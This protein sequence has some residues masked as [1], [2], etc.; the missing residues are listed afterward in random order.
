MYVR[1]AVLR[2]NEYSSSLL[3]VFQA[4]FELRD[5]GELQPHEEEW[6]EQELR[7]LRMHLKSPSC[8]HD[9]GNHRAICWFHPRAKR[10]IAKV[11]SIAALLNE[12]GCHV[13]M[14][15][16]RDPGT[17]IYED[18]FQ[19]VAKPLRRKRKVDESEGR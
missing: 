16:T 13:R 17:V 5:R 1:F 6:L 2:K 3:G 19:V 11:R 18:G 14:L 4:A 8:L 7:W 10:P 12:K 9:P 15:T